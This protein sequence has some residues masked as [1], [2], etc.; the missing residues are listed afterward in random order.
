M[1]AGIYKRRDNGLHVYVAKDR[2]IRAIE[3]ADCHPSDGR[4]KVTTSEKEQ[5]V[6]FQ[7]YT[8]DMQNLGAVVA[9]RVADVPNGTT[10]HVL[11]LQHYIVCEAPMPAGVFK[12]PNGNLVYVDESHNIRAASLSPSSWEGLSVAYYAAINAI[13]F[14]GYECTHYANVNYPMYDGM[15]P[16][17]VLEKLQGDTNALRRAV[18]EE[19][20]EWAIEKAIEDGSTIYNVEPFPTIYVTAAVDLAHE[21]FTLDDTYDNWMALGKAL[22]AAHWHGAEGGRLIWHALSK[23]SAKYDEAVLDDRWYAFSG[24]HRAG[25]APLQSVDELRSDVQKGEPN[26]SHLFPGTQLH[27]ASAKTEQEFLEQAW[28]SIADLLE[29]GVIRYVAGGEYEI[30]DHAAW[31]EFWMSTRPPE[32]PNA[33]RHAAFRPSELE[34]WGQGACGATRAAQSSL[35]RAPMTASEIREVFAKVS[36][37][38]EKY[39]KAFPISAAMRGLMIQE[40]NAGMRMHAQTQDLVAKGIIKHVMGDEYVVVDIEAFGKESP[41]GP[42]VAADFSKL[43][44]RVVGMHPALGMPYGITAEKRHGPF[45]PDRYTKDYALAE[46]EVAGV[47]SPAEFI[48]TNWDPVNDHGWYAEFLAGE[49]PR[50]VGK[51]SARKQRKKGRRVWWDAER[52]TRVWA[53]K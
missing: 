33:R 21:R 8:P 46:G 49:R 7:D 44:E 43:E 45:A 22:W 25:S 12:T 51:Q 11:A 18:L 41:L 42:L 36:D 3:L 48:V 4:V 14:C 39:R 19:S 32:L 29:R 2:S 38:V 1:K 10:D 9:D 37:D 53:P 17:Q 35:P 16:A 27:M 15:T 6:A 23:R 28:A 13:K 26:V 30:L 5:V 20:T 47:L 24:I 40:Q 34:Q 31:R 50:A 52:N